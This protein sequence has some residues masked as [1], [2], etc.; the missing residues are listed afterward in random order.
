[1]VQP[2]SASVLITPVAI[3]AS[4]LP[5]R[6]SAGATKSF[7]GE[8]ITFFH[9]LV[10]ARLDE[11]DLLVAVDLV[12]EDVV[13]GDAADGFDGEGLAVELDLVALHYFLH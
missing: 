4:V 12:A 13:P 7:N 11:G 3:N 1:M 8:D 2:S 10:G 6:P 9:A 5:S